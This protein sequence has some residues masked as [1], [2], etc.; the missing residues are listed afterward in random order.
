MRVLDGSSLIEHQCAGGYRRVDVAHEAVLERHHHRYG[1]DG[2]SGFVAEHGMVDAFYIFLAFFAPFQVGD[3]LYFAG[4][5]FHE[6]ASAPFG[7]RLHAHLL[8]LLF[9]DVLQCHIDGGGD[10]ITRHGGL[11]HHASHTGGYLYVFSH[12]GFAVEE[13]VERH[14]QAAAAVYLTVLS[15]F[16]SANASR[17]HCSIGLGAHFYRR[18]VE[19]ALVAS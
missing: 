11:F 7:S 14:L 16:H 13:R 8:Q 9:Y 12:T 1:F 6:H 17:S 4:S 15:F 3:S 5:H 19:S 2:R 10:V 18:G